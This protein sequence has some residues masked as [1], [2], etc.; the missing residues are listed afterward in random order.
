MRGDITVRWIDSRLA[1]LA[2][3][4]I[5]ALVTFQACASA[6]A[7]S[8]RVS[9]GV[10]AT[11]GVL[12]GVTA[13]VGFVVVQ[14]HVM[15]GDGHDRDLGGLVAVVVVSALVGSLVD[16]WGLIGPAAAA[17]LVAFPLRAGA[18]L[19]LGVLAADH[20]IGL[21]EGT[22]VGTMASV[23]TTSA[24]VAAALYV[25]T[26]MVVVLG[27]L[28]RAQEELVRVSIDHERRRMSRDVHDLLGRSLVSAGL[29]IQVGLR[30]VGND[31]QGCREQ[32]EQAARAITDGQCTLRHVVNGADLAALPD[33]LTAA[34]D[35]LVRLGIP[36]DVVADRLP[37]DDHRELTARV[38]RE[39]V[40]NLL[41]HAQPS[42]VRI[43]LRP[44]AGES[45]LRIDNDGASTT[46]PAPHGGTG[47]RDL[48]DRAAR[49]GGRLESSRTGPD[50]FTLTLRLPLVPTAPTPPAPASPVD[51]VRF[52]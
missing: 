36:C 3:W 49:A 31:P 32:L 27:E 38:V 17:A 26:R 15:W 39:G 22:A 46:S 11:L 13:A 4:S 8:A 42:A 18:L 30:L 34:R 12:A 24:A 45:L 25:L 21:L 43:A 40:T 19:G 51:D 9:S 16:V 52:R 37:P 1:V 33:E 5:V 20:L 7:G 28:G 41:K 14:R 44:E 50:G 47:L 48:A 23:T 29:R 2:S 10:L 35:L 6:L